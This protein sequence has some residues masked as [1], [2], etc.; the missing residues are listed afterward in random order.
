MTSEFIPV[1]LAQLWQVTLLILVVAAVNRWFTQRRPH[2]SHLL[3]LVVLVKC[4]TPPLWSSPGGVF[5][6]LQSEVPIGT[7]V[8]TDAELSSVA[9]KELLDVGTVTVFDSEVSSD[10][11]AGVI[12]DDVEADEL[13]H[14]ANV[15]K[16]PDTDVVP[17]E[18]GV[19]SLVVWLTVSL[20]VLVG[21]TVRWLSFWRLVRS[22]SQ[23]ESPELVLLLESLSRQ[24]GVRRRVR[25]IVT[26]SLVGP[27]VIGFFRVTVLIPAVV[28]DKLQGKSVAPILAHELL[29]I[30]RGDLWVGMLQTV[31]QAL[32]WFHP[33]VWW[34]SQM[35][36]REAERCC[37]E[38]VLGELKCDPASYARALLDVLD[39]K[40]QLKPVPVFPGVRPVD[41]TSQRLERIMT[42]RQGCQRRSPWWCWLVAIGAAVLTLPGAAFVVSADAPTE[43]SSDAE[44][45]ASKTDGTAE[46]KEASKD[47]DRTN[48]GA[49]N[50]DN[51]KPASSGFSDTKQASEKPIEAVP[52]RQGGEETSAAS[53]HSGR[54]IFRHGGC[55]LEAI[56][57]EGS[58]LDVAIDAEGI[59]VLKAPLTLMLTRTEVFGFTRPLS[60]Q[61]DQCR[62]S[63]GKSLTIELS[64]NVVLTAPHQLIRAKANS[65][66]MTIQA[67]G[68]AKAE[69]GIQCLMKNVAMT[70]Q[71]DPAKDS[72]LLQAEEINFVLDANTF[73]ATEVSASKVESL[74]VSDAKRTAAERNGLSPVFAEDRQLL[75]QWDTIRRR[76]SL[77]K[78]VSPKFDRTPLKEAIA[79]FRTTGDLNIILDELGLEEEG[80]AS[81]TPVTIELNEVAIHSA[82]RLL[83]KPLNLGITIDEESSVVIV[84]SQLRMQGRMVA[85]AYPVA[86]LVIPIPKSVVVRLS[87]DGAYILQQDSE[88]RS[89]GVTLVSGVAYEH[90]QLDMDSISELITTVVE[91]DSWQEVGGLGT[92]RANETTLSLVIR[93]TQDVH[94]EISNLLDQLRRL[95]DIQV[96]VQGDVLN[97][98]EQ[99]LSGLKFEAMENSPEHRFA[100]LSKDQAA[101]LRTI[102]QPKSL[103]R[104]TLFNGQKCE[105]LFGDESSGHGRLSL[106]PVASSDR[107]VVRLSLRCQKQSMGKVGTTFSLLPQLPNGT[108][109][110]LDVT[111]SL[112]VATLT[113]GNRTFLLLTPEVLVVDE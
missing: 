50:S 66:L 63:Q 70:I 86:D 47:T 112:P 69:N 6:W 72:S 78:L 8:A 110:L 23:R 65:L 60:M 35:T 37:D 28:A 12:L 93:Q 42:L 76:R 62:I 41:V 52:K 98:P 58:E 25:L 34:V 103:P 105:L 64:G 14:N 16:S 85:A 83:L 97:V 57:R 87:D 29:H 99:E 40:S 104:M 9:W 31:A 54:L 10:E 11:F 2:L 21:V 81:T 20:L 90:S 95:H 48:S 68:N 113:S 53:L 15:F 101:E 13:L 74:R 59:A 22:S 44:Q 92:L 30:R 91:P 26:E 73:K 24:L 80:I 49:G 109:V 77:Q 1:A 107:S 17:T 84:T 5:C 88:P 46:S 82:L 67:G 96:V 3:W 100:V 27:A 106:Q 55:R 61:A 7:T 51:I 56:P 108:P 71:L 39:L 111:G 38:E 75:S 19:V 33:L 89:G 45:P 43:S 18:V 36:T 102:G 32:W 94:R 79:W 4:V